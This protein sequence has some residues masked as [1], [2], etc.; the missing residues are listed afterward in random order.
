[1]YKKVQKEIK[2]TASKHGT[3]KKTGLDTSWTLSLVRHY[4]LLTSFYYPIK[5]HGMKNI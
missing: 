1:M 2:G 4:F 5:F 3:L